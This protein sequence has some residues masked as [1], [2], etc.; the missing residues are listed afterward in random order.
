MPPW[1]MIITAARAT[2]TVDRKIG[3]AFDFC[4]DEFPKLD[5]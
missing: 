5:G 4:F 2:G 3:I 1:A